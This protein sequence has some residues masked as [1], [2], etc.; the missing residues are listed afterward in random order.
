MVLVTG[1]A[2]QGKLDYAKKRYGVTDG[3]IDG[4]SCDFSRITTCRGIHH[5]HE[6]VRRMAGAEEPDPAEGSESQ[7]AAGQ[8]DRLEPGVPAAALIILGE[9]PGAG[10]EC[11]WDFRT[12]DLTALEEQAE[13]FAFWLLR[14]NPD[15][16]IVTDELGCGIV[17]ME[18]RDRL[19][20]EM[21]GRICTCLAAKADEVTRVVC[22]I[23][24]RL[25]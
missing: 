16:V 10:Q 25:K 4:R 19:W 7:N 8:A 22:G 9:R 14:E 3:W 17:P 13:A 12:A 5:F 24:T 23:G 20:R 11:I 6:Y 1:G 21:T 2:Y 18:K 15:L